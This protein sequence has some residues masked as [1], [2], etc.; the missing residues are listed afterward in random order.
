MNNSFL[1]EILSDPEV[2]AQV[3]PL[4]SAA[5]DARLSPINEKLEQL[6]QGV[7]LLAQ[8]HVEAAQ[9]Q[10][11]QAQP[12]QAQPQAQQFAGGPPVGQPQQNGYAPPTPQGYG[13]PAGAPAPSGGDKLAAFAPLLMQYLQT[14]Q[15][16]SGSQSLAGVADTLGIAASIGNAMNAP[17][18]QG[19]RMA[20]ELMALAGRAGIEP[21]TAAETL[22]GMVDNATATKPATDGTNTPG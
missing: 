2:M 17:M 9:A 15:N 6:A 14:Q 22:G 12:V 19:M 4:L 13:Q 18:Y 11:P 7:T 3:E 8:A 16:G 1:G 10:Q 21:V 20:T 5:I